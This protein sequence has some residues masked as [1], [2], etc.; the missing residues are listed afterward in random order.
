MAQEL[1]DVGYPF[2]ALKEQRGTGVPE[3][4]ERPSGDSPYSRSRRD[5]VGTRDEAPPCAGAAQIA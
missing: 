2:P 3:G 5:L 1:G 4:M